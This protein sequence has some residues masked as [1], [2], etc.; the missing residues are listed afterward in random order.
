[1][2]SIRY[3]RFLAILLLFLLI[4]AVGCSSNNAEQSAQQKERIDETVWQW[5]EAKN[6]ATSTLDEYNTKNS[7]SFGQEMLG[8]LGKMGEAQ[9]ELSDLAGETENRDLRADAQLCSKGMKIVNQ[10]T[11]DYGGALQV[12]LASVELGD[13]AEITRSEEALGDAHEKYL[14]ELKKGRDMM[15]RSGL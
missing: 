2:I 13:D 8:A 4:G 10:S 15:N 14:K 7:V 11:R 6:M 3:G 9:D 1:M 5:N 12:F